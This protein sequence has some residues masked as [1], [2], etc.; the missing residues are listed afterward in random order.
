MSPMSARR[1]PEQRVKP[2]RIFPDA[3][4]ASMT[5]DILCRCSG[6]LNLE[7][8]SA[9]AR[10]C[11]LAIRAFA[12][13]VCFMPSAPRGCPYLAI[14]RLALADA[15][16]LNSGDPALSLK[17]ILACAAFFRFGFVRPKA[18][19]L[20]QTLWRLRPSSLASRMRLT[21]ESMARAY[22]ERSIATSASDH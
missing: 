3:I 17:L 11:A 18:L 10:R 16:A 20:R 22:A 12:S 2:D 14:E 4:R 13:G 21:G 1:P 15:K 6:V 19:A 7:A 5:S 8:G 9:H